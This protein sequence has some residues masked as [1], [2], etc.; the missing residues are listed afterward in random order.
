MR[1]ALDGLLSI[2]QSRTQSAVFSATRSILETRRWYDIF[3]VSSLTRQRFVY[4]LQAADVEARLAEEAA[5]QRARAGEIRR[6]ARLAKIKFMEE[7]PD[8]TEAR[9]KFFTLM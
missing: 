3:C 2:E 8:N 7:M 6:E 9:A 5:D 1:V 4:F